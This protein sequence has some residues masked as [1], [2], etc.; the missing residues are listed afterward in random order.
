MEQT[1]SDSESETVTITY[2]LRVQ[3][4]PTQGLV[5]NNLSF[6]DN[7]NDITFDGILLKDILTSIMNDDG[8]KTIL[9]NRSDTTHGQQLINQAITS[10]NTLSRTKNAKYLNESENLTRIAELDKSF[11]IETTSSLSNGNYPKIMILDKLPVL[12]N[13]I[14][15]RR[16]KSLIIAY[17]QLNGIIVNDGLFQIGKYG[18]TKIQSNEIKE[19][20]FKDTSSK[21]TLSAFLFFVAKTF[22]RIPIVLLT[23]STD[24][25][26]V[27]SSIGDNNNNKQSI[28][29]L[30]K[31][32]KTD[33]Y[34]TDITQP[35]VNAE[36]NTKLIEG[37]QKTSK[38]ASNLYN[39]YVNSK[40]PISIDMICF[41]LISF[42]SL[43]TSANYDYF[44][45]AFCERL[46]YIINYWCAGISDNKKYSSKLG[47]LH[48]SEFK[49]TD[50]ND[51][52]QKVIPTRSFASIL[53]KIH[54]TND[55]LITFVKI[56]KGRVIKDPTKDNAIIND[57][58][59]MNI[60]YSGIP[61]TET[62]EKQTDVL[63][64]DGKIL[65]FRYD[66][67]IEPFYKQS[68]NVLLPNSTKPTLLYTRN[69]VVPDYK[70]DFNI[71]P[72]TRIY[73]ETSTNETIA[74]KSN[75]FK[76]KIRDKLIESGDPVCI[77]G[78]GS[79]G[80]G[81]TSVLIQLSQPNEAPQ[82][83]I[84][85]YL[86]N[87]L[88]E[89]GYNNCS[90]QIIEFGKNG[91]EYKD[92][93]VFDYNKMTGDV[94]EGAFRG[95]YIYNTG[96][97]WKIKGSEFS[98]SSETKC[99]QGSMFNDILYFME[100][101]R[102]VKTTPNNPVSSRTHVIISMTY[103]DN[104]S[105]KTRQLFICD[106]AGVE[107]TFDCT[108]IEDR[109]TTSITSFFTE[110]NIGPEAC[111]ES[112]SD[113]PIGN[114]QVVR[115]MASIIESST[116]L[117]SESKQLSK[118]LTHAVNNGHTPS[119]SAV[120]KGRTP[121]A[122]AV[123]NQPQNDKPSENIQVVPN[124]HSEPAPTSSK[125]NSQYTTFGN[126]IKVNKSLTGGIPLNT[127]INSLKNYIAYYESYDQD[128]GKQIKTVLPQFE[129]I[130]DKII[131]NSFIRTNQK[132]PI[133][134]YF[135][136]VKNYISDYKNDVESKSVENINTSLR[137]LAN[138]ID[139]L[140]SVNV[141]NTIIKL[142]C[143]LNGNNL[144]YKANNVTNDRHC[145]ISY[146]TVNIETPSMVKLKMIKSL[147]SNKFSNIIKIIKIIENFSEN[148]LGRYDY[149][150]Y[151]TYNAN[152]NMNKP[153][154]DRNSEILK[155]VD[156]LSKFLL[157]YVQYLFPVGSSTVGK[158]P[159][160]FANIKQMKNHKEP[161][162]QTD[163]D[164]IR[165]HDNF[166]F[167][168]WNA[169]GSDDFY[170]LIT[171]LNLNDYTDLDN[172]TYGQSL[173][174]ISYTDSQNPKLSVNVS[175]NDAL[176]ISVTYDS[177]ND[178]PNFTQPN[179]KIINPL[180]E[181]GK[182]Q[183]VN[184][185]FTR[186][187]DNPKFLN[188]INAKCYRVDGKS[189]EM[190]ITKKPT[191]LSELKSIFNFTI[192]LN[193]IT[194]LFT[195]LTTIYENH[196]SLFNALYELKHKK[197]IKDN[198]KIPYLFY[199][200]S[201]FLNEFTPEY[202]EF[203]LH[204]MFE[205]LRYYVNKDAKIKNNENYTLE[206]IDESL[207]EKNNKSSGGAIQ[208][209]G[210]TLPEECAYRTLEG[211][212]I[213]AFL[214][215][216]REGIAKYV[217]DVNNKKGL[218]SF[219]TKCLPIQCSPE[220][221]ECLGVDNYSIPK[222][223]TKNESYGKL[224]DTVKNLVE[225]ENNIV[226]CVLCVMNFSEPGLAK[227]P[228]PIPYIDITELQQYY[229]ILENIEYEKTF[230]DVK[231]IIQNILNCMNTIINDDSVKYYAD[232]YEKGLILSLQ[233]NYL[234]PIIEN[235]KINNNNAGNAGDNTTYKIDT[236]VDIVDSNLRVII[237]NVKAFIEFISNI[238]AA[239]MIGTGLFTDS[240]AKNFVEVNTCNATKNINTIT[241]D[242][243]QTTGK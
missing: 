183:D 57:G 52:G 55:N 14:F 90:V 239:T 29:S 185:T 186:I 215:E 182:M 58:K 175:V 202:N 120:S 64:Q 137:K 188:S 87:D 1:N 236:N 39:S 69:Y 193:K 199:L 158:K 98:M 70:Y 111:P 129:N 130:A 151:N 240:V 231:L 168:N 77:I 198:E 227:D 6:N 228:P 79:S 144:K 53:Q 222:Q 100:Y 67:K 45:I 174:I 159:T 139:D 108:K 114:N 56:R 23:A 63:T 43:E 99:T 156:T 203:Q 171:P 140:K 204:M 102:L 195:N 219:F 179:I 154:T 61:D 142:I 113:A 155:K 73:D 26:T 10:T 4:N 131:N 40:T 41:L 110:L 46:I 80:S 47:Y 22:M 238:N 36:V 224:V 94:N 34:P 72:F 126:M 107:N 21:K 167:E 163:T 207:D 166:S 33:I 89:K 109:D 13:D 44:I 59:T 201:N 105:S 38:T 229:K 86:S 165:F 176:E 96:T 78:Y 218:P 30:Y 106:L 138:V 209:G 116:K 112:Q 149:D 31:K 184:C 125:T 115:K 153:I 117:Q 220:F 145:I 27:E 11:S 15:N 232:K 49:V 32:L 82:P 37:I 216:M 8:L 42:A 233:T 146:K 88:G 180:I 192:P 74:T 19:E 17:N 16:L 147:F 18:K 143:D 181:N 118:Q 243:K 172:A 75:I 95:Q 173:R 135:N 83:G 66:P 200:K 177:I 178:S 217:R 3:N 214:K 7:S 119:A 208:K 161:T 226:F 237:M 141:P 5:F 97:G 104:S 160:R 24:V 187:F 68:E 103:K 225:N 81:K 194:A 35:G 221:K 170:N 92:G 84:L 25:N 211:K 196:K 134:N 162:S 169:E 242:V 121:S 71:G 210:G 122:Q 205:H 2:N 60:R 132:F 12:D 91:K 48:S 212:Y 230:R 93:Y 191:E 50:T 234:N 62:P 190:P 9:G 157:R 136:T 189:D 65:Q 223:N 148:N 213:N 133:G 206:Y 123:S 28:I 127:G 85:M 150:K 197:K 241:Y 164:A 76:T 124:Q 101:Q 51:D 54:N 20:H 235:I 128:F 152:T